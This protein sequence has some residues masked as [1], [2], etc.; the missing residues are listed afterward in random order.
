[1]A[2]F[3]HV[4]ARK[5]YGKLREITRCK[6]LLRFGSKSVDFLAHAF[7][8]ENEETRGKALSPREKMEV[9]LRFVGDPGFQSGIG[10]DMGIH[11]TTVCKTIDS[12]LN[13][14]VERSG[15]WIHF[16]ARNNKINEAKLLWQRRFRLPTSPESVFH[17]CRIE[18]I[19]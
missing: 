4:R 3:M 9:F 8:P 1:M 16:P 5:F 19:A 10:E 11:R 2:E 7:L 12:V 14:I 17:R 18:A 13:N 6:E 15:N